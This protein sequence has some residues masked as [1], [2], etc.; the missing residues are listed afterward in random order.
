[1]P[2]KKTKPPAP[3]SAGTPRP[4]GAARVRDAGRSRGAILKAAIAVFSELGLGGARVDEIARR[5]GVNKALLY[6]YFDNKDGLFVAALEC[7]YEEIRAAEASLDLESLGPEAA[8]Q[9]LVDF[10][11]DHFL[12]HPEFI[13][14]LN[15]ENLHRARHLEKSGSVRQLHLPLVARLKKLL[16][17]G[18]REGVFRDG[19]DPVELYISV[20]SLGY[21]YLSNAHTLSTVFS[22]DLMGPAALRRRRKHMRDVILGYLRPMEKRVRSAG[23][24]REGRGKA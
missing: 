17:R 8:I 7:V 14:L 19:V 5:A 13:T 10:T 22:R 3:P 23:P 2:R 12:A 9:R 11:F 24:G 15:S 20:A 21:F 1:M 6:H 4:A 16:A 18:A